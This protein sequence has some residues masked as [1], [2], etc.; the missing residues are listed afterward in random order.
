MTFVKIGI[1]NYNPLKN[2]LCKNSVWSSSSQLS[3]D[4][5]W[6]YVTFR[7]ELVMIVVKKGIF[8]RG[9]VPANLPC[10]LADARG[11]LLTHILPISQDLDSLRHIFDPHFSNNHVQLASVTN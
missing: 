7:S 6:L 9:N 10:L 4:A 3:E 5:A 1:A 11:V 8:W 2:P